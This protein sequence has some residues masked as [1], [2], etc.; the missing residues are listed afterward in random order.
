M[1]RSQIAAVFG[2]KSQGG[3]LS[4]WLKDVPPPDWT[5]RPNAKDDVRELAVALRREGK[6]YREI[7][8][9]LGVSK[10]SLSLWLRDVELTDAQL[11]LLQER[12][13]RSTTRAHQGIRT[14]HELRRAKVVEDARAQIPEAICESELFVAGVV[15]YWAEGS[16]HKPWRSGNLVKFTNSD[17]EMIRLFMRWLALLGYAPTDCAF[18]VAIHESADVREAELFWAEL[19]GVPVDHFGTPNLK[20]HNPKTVRH[21][22]GQNYRGC[23]VVRVRKSSDFYRQILGWWQGIVAAA[24]L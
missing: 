4:V 2:F 24:D 15:A 8:E 23:L 10:S 6:S 19:V 18:N 12:R 20:R 7:H 21:N 11:A 14:R 16:K 3:A 13:A 22:T 5:R 17:P 9:Q 1:S